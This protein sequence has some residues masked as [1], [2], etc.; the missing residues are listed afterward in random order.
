V[1]TPQAYIDLDLILAELWT[2]LTYEALMATITGKHKRITAELLE[3]GVE[4]L[5]EDGYAYVIN[6]KK[7]VIGLEIENKWMIRR[8]YKGQMLVL[9]GGYSRLYQLTETRRKGEIRRSVA[10]TV[11]T[12]VA[13]L[14]AIALVGWEIYKQFCLPK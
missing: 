9:D 14:G 3:Q 1:K 5:R 2:P 10:L 6:D 13:G 12:L 4:K 8:S 7:Y 11:G